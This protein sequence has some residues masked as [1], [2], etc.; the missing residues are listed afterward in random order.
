MTVRIPGRIIPQGTATQ[1]GLPIAGDPNTGFGGDGADALWAIQ[2]A[3]RTWRLFSDGTQINASQ[4]CVHAR[5]TATVTGQTGNQAV[6]TV[7]FDSEIVDQGAD[8]D[9]TTFTAPQA[10]KVLALGQ[11]LLNN[12]TATYVDTSLRFLTSNRDYL[13]F[14]NIPTSVASN[15]Y[16]VLGGSIIDF[17]ANDTMTMAVRSDR[18]TATSLSVDILGSTTD[19]RTSLSLVVVA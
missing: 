9:G 11:A 7:T 17:D 18:V 1:P 15:I 19:N 2:N 8:F 16:H 5:K 6:A 4:P 3:A 12:L 10:C 13:P 14:I